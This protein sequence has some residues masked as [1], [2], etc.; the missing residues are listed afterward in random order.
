MTPSNY[1]G[2]NISCFGSATG[3]INLTI[4]G[5]TPPYSIIWSNAATTEDLSNVS[6]GYYRVTVDDADTLTDTGQYSQADL[7]SAAQ[8]SIDFDEGNGLPT[9][10]PCDAPTSFYYDPSQFSTLNT[11]TSSYLTGRIEDQDGKAIKNAAILALNWLYTV[12]LTPG[13]PGGEKHIHSWVHTFTN[14]NTV[15]NNFTI[16]PYTPFNPN[17]PRIVYIKATAVGASKVELGTWG[18]DVAMNSNLVTIVLDKINFD[19]DSEIDNITISASSLK[20]NYSGWNSLNVTNST[21]NSGVTSELVARHEININP[22][23]NAELGSDVHIYLDETFAECIDYT[24]FLRTFNPESENSQG[25]LSSNQQQIKLS[26]QRSISKL[27]INPNPSSGNYSVK[28]DSEIDIKTM[29]LIIRN[30]LGEEMMKK[31]FAGFEY[32]I[33]LSN[34]ING[35]Y[36]LE[37][38]NNEQKFNEIL[39]KN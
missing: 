33:D 20:K 8:V 21:I 19:Y 24:G 15:G 34:F 26:F 13:F 35:I 11:N 6:A 4:T 7:K 38:F 23:F 29:N 37:L 9:L 14:D 12:D 28:I 18:S 30:T 1:N 5:G 16:I 31:E 17:D 32:E 22:S 2:Y 3:S 39:V 27:N 10:S 25:Y 36:F